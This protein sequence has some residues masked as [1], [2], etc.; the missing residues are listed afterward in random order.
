M[1]SDFVNLVCELDNI[2]DNKRKRYISICVR[3]GKIKY[4]W[5][6]N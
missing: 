1:K 3:L 6:I 4:E 2:L 5:D